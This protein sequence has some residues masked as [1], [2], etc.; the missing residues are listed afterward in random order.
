MLTITN[1]SQT[2]VVTKGAYNSMYASQGWEITTDKIA[3]KNDDF[4]VVSENKEITQGSSKEQNLLIK[5]TPGEQNNDE[6]EEEDDDDEVDLSEIPL[7]EMSVP[8]MK[9][10]AKQLGIEVNTDSARQLRTQ[11]RKTLEG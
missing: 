2:L 8:Q 9:L 11:I 6:P 10:Y 7:S 3:T 5:T 1:G 4:S